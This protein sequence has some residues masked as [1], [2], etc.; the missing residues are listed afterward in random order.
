MGLSFLSGIDAGPLASWASMFAALKSRRGRY[1]RREI[2]KWIGRPVPVE[3]LVPDSAER[4]RPL[5]RGA[6]QFTFEHL[7]DRR[8]ANKGVQQ[9]ELFRHT[10]PEQRPPPPGHK[11]ARP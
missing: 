7:S 5:G 2:G 11:N 9:V 6:F 8:P 10:E 4:W 1:W 3:I